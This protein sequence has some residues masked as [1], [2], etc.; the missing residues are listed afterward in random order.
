[1]GRVG[2]AVMLMALVSALPS[3][4]SAQKEAIVADATVRLRLAEIQRENAERDL[5]QAETEVIRAEELVKKY[6][7][8]AAYGVVARQDLEKAE[9]DAEQARLRLAAVQEVVALAREVVERAKDYLAKARAADGEPSSPSPHPLITRV[10]RSAGR[11]SWTNEDF[12]TLLREFKIRFHTDLPV[13]AYGQ[14]PTHDRLGLNHHGRID[15]ALHPESEAGQWVIR[16]LSE[17]GI[18]YIAFTGQV[19]QSATGAHIHIGPPSTKK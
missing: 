7:A 10:S 6:R 9:S 13:S 2:K 18:P 5:S 4:T 3:S 14:T 11:S 12:S 15:V 8:L 19:P 17:R 16:F 1:M